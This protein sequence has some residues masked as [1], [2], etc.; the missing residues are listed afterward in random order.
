[1][2]SGAYLATPLILHPSSFILAPV[3]QNK[4][5][6]GA[7][8][9]AARISRRRSSFILHPSSLPPSCGIDGVHGVCVH[10][11]VGPEL[12]KFTTSVPPPLHP[13]VNF[14]YAGMKLT[15]LPSHFVHKL[16]HRRAPRP[17]SV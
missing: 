6:G 14:S 7:A 5:E 13:W 17:L 10:A 11:P 16:N 8:W 2:A 9:R 15:R 1:M 4:D 3:V 12:K